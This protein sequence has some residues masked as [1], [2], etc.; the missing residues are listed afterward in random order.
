MLPCADLM[1]RKFEDLVPWTVTEKGNGFECRSREEAKITEDRFVNGRGP[2]AITPA[3]SDAVLV[4]SYDWST[5]SREY[6][7]KKVHLSDQFAYSFLFNPDFECSF[8]PNGIVIK[9]MYDY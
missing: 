6:D 7:L 2:G 9:V 8:S 4:A 3:S 1:W 5:R